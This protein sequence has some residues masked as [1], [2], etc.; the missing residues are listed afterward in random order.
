MDKFPTVDEL[1]R[2]AKENPEELNRI[3]EKF[4]NEIIDNAREENKARLK[5]MMFQMN[6]IRL[7][8]KDNHLKSTI[9]MSKLMWTSFYKMNDELQQFKKEQNKLSLVD[10]NKRD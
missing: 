9:A 5:G 10:K 1:M 8:N 4:S 3:Q 2:L 7:K 6:A